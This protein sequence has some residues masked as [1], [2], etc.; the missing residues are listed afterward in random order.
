MDVHDV[1]VVALGERVKS[2]FG[3]DVY[4]VTLQRAL[5]IAARNTIAPA[6]VIGETGPNADSVPIG[7]TTDAVLFALHTE[8]L[9]LVRPH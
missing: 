3:E 4:K 9:K 5:A 2:L 8:F 6:A 7:L 1:D